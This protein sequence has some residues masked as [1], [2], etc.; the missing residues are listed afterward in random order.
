MPKFKGIP[1]TNSRAVETSILCGLLE[2]TCFFSELT[3]FHDP[4]MHNFLSS[5]L[6]FLGC[7]SSNTFS[8]PFFGGNKLVLHL[9]PFPPEKLGKIAVFVY[10]YFILKNEFNQYEI[11]S[12][13]ISFSQKPFLHCDNPPF[14]SLSMRSFFTKKGAVFQLEII[15]NVLLENCQFV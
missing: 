4:F 7:F 5:E 11:H 10:A 9:Y 2:K 15:K 13:Q 3:K 8:I 1:D 12:N 14:I 6:E